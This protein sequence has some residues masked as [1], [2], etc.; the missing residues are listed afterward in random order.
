VN[1]YG[2]RYVI[3]CQGCSHQCVGCQNPET[4]D[5]HGGIEKAP[6]ELVADIKKHKHIDGVTLSGGDPF[7]QQDECVS[8][9]KL[10]PVNLDVWIYTGF[11]Y[12]EIKDTQLARMADYIVDG[13]FEQ[14]KIVTGK[15]YGSSNQKIINV[16]I[17][18]RNIDSI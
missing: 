5:F 15:M 11:N 3:F 8:F 4:W 17:E 2:I 1:G 18:E 16:K 7:Y 9:L 6:E 14:D 13:K 10:L 12:E